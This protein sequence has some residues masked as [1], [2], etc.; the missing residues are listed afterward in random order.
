MTERAKHSF[1]RWA[2]SLHLWDINQS[3]TPTQNDWHLP[4]LIGGV[5]Y[6]QTK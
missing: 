4:Q 1:L 6:H 3:L 2:I 5:A